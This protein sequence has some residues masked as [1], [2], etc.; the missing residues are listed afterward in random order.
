MP[1]LPR[2]L[3]PRIDYHCCKWWSLNLLSIVLFI[4]SVL[5]PL[6]VLF[7][8]YRDPQFNDLGDNFDPATRS[9]TISAVLYVL[10]AVL[11]VL[12]QLLTFW[13][14]D[15]PELKIVLYTIHTL[16]ISA[17]GLQG[18]KAVF[19]FHAIATDL[20][21]TRIV[22]TQ[23]DLTK[24][25][26]DIMN[27]TIGVNLI[28][29][30][31]IWE[32]VHL[33]GYECDCSSLGVMFLRF[34]HQPFPRRQY[35]NESPVLPL[36]IPPVSMAKP[37]PAYTEFSRHTAA[38]STESVYKTPDYAQHDDRDGNFHSIKL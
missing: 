36:Q 1:P 5:F 23:F 10:S 2:T 30:L 31:L 28:L 37:A 12:F 35:K 6:K 3:L 8:V 4:I 11:F 24:A 32:E 18:V 21:P 20:S 7:T 9:F 26:A 33:M 13:N 17:G 14:N 19:L 15:L 29:V 27:G 22:T 38:R 25:V 16:L 34:L